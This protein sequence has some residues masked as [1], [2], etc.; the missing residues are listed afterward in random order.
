MVAARML[1]FQEKRSPWG[2][3]AH[4][5]ESRDRFVLKQKLG[6]NCVCSPGVSFLLLSFRSVVATIAGSLRIPAVAPGLCTLKF[7][8]NTDRP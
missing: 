8:S 7:K 4:Q 1:S 3:L 5:N 2:R 6:I